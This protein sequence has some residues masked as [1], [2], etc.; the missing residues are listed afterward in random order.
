VGAHLANAAASGE[1]RL[2]Y[3]RDKNRDV[4]FVVEAERRLFAVEVKSGRRRDA[5]PGL[6]AFTQVEKRARPVLIGGDGIPIAEALTRPA[7]EWV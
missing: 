3:W 2:S 1:C 5:L 6:A 7:N 4:D